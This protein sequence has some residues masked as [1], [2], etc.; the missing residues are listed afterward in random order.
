MVSETKC[1]GALITQVYGRS[2]V[3]FVC[4][5]GRR[6]GYVFMQMVPTRKPNSVVSNATGMC[7]LVAQVYCRPVSLLLLLLSE[8]VRPSSAL[9]AHRILL[10]PGRPECPEPVLASPYEVEALSEKVREELIRGNG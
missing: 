2:A 5:P 1:P 8:W 9:E 7:K 3:F 6:D 4:L 10:R